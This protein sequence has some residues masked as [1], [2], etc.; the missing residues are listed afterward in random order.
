[1]TTGDGSHAVPDRPIKSYG[2]ATDPAIIRWSGG[3][4]WIAHPDERMRRASHALVVDDAVLVVEP[5]DFDGLDD[6]LASLGTVAGVVVL[7][8]LHRRDAATLAERHDVP[9]Y[10]PS[11]VG[12]LTPRID[13]P[14]EVFDGDLADTGFREIP[15]LDGHPWSEAVLHDPE[16]G[17]LVATE[18]LVTSEEAVGPG[19]RLA[20]GPYARLIPPRDALGGLAVERVLVGHG[21]PILTDA[22]AALRDALANSRRGLPAYLLR[23]VGFMLKAGY[24]ALRD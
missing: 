19:E 6:L 8:G 18:V 14:V 21:D 22:E 5:N 13:A 3:L 11:V 2:R 24:V 16:T 10:L 15:V 9:V 12:G 7:A 1:M 20:V 4:T 23:D 17:T